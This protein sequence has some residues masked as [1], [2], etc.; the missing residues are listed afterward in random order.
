MY[1]CRGIKSVKFQKVSIM[2]KSTDMVQVKSIYLNL[3]M[4]QTCSDQVITNEY[5][6]FLAKTP[7]SRERQSL[8]SEKSLNY[9][10]QTDH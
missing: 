2:S 5:F 6:C 7:C 4:Q 1:R 9:S 10:L 3:L 8:K